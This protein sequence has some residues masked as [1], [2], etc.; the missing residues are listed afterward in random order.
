VSDKKASSQAAWAL[1]T[2]GVS[3][4]RVL[5]HRIRHLVD[6]IEK[7][8]NSDQ[9][10]VIYQLLGDVVEGLPLQVNSLERTLDRTSYALS[11]M[12]Q[13]FLRGRIS[14]SDRTHVE[15]AVHST[16]GFSK[17]SAERVV[18]RHRDKVAK[19]KAK[20]RGV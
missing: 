19:R 17:D 12:G 2:C 5:A 9:S 3:E 8:A 20:Y 13:D 14:L 4:S 10:E 7:L 1:L 16:Q 18:E 11:K 6:R 15:E